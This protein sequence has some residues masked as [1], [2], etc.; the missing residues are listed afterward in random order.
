MAF[1]LFSNPASPIAINFGSTSV[2]M[3]QLAPTRDEGDPP[4]LAAA[5]ELAVPLEA[6]QNVDDLFMFYECELPGLL[7][8]AGFKGRRAVC[9]VPENQTIVQ[10]LQIP[11]NAGGSLDEQVK[12]QLQMQMG[13]APHSAVVRTVEVSDFSRAGQGRTEVICFAIPRELVMRYISLFAKFKIEVIG[14]HTGM[15]SMVRAFDH[16]HQRKGDENLTSLY[17]DLGYSGTRVAIAHGKQIVFARAIEV[18]GQHF[19]Q[20]IASQ[21]ECDMDA[22]RAHRLALQATGWQRPVNTAVQSSHA[23][24]AQE[25]MRASLDSTN[26]DPATSEKYTSVTVIEGERRKGSAPPAL[27]VEVDA[28]EGAVTPVGRV[29]PAELLDTISDELSMCLRYHQGLFPNRNIDRTILVGGEA[30]QKWLCQYVVRALRLPAQLGDPLARLKAAS[31]PINTP[32]VDMNQ[33][34]PG[35]TVACG[36]SATLE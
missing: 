28:G 25:S 31:E 7:R 24:S 35:W 18:G 8:K 15:M 6:Q 9:S 30:R 36:L 33:P 19:D 34:Q 13:I 5:A 27:A 12:M 10:H 21:L 29:D 32:G 3:L 2:K 22:A 26:G 11:A 17:I 4:A 23:E 14:V 1:R 16:I 20:L